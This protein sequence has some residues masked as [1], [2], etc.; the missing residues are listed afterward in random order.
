MSPSF[1]GCG[2][3]RGREGRRGEEKRGQGRKGREEDKERG[4]GEGDI[5]VEE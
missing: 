4:E 1:E 2:E 5:R 3:G